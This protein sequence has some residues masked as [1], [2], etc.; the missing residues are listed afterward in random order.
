MNRCLVHLFVSLGFFKSAHNVMISHIDTMGWVGA[1]PPPRSC[2]QN[3]IVAF[4]KNT[5]SGLE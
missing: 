2:V 3:G 5:S 1:F 4:Q